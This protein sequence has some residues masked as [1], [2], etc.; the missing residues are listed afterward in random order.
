MVYVTLATRGGMEVRDAD[1]KVATIA[2]LP[3]RLKL[4]NNFS[5]FYYMIYDVQIGRKINCHFV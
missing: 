2:S 3:H 1:L 4:V 5:T